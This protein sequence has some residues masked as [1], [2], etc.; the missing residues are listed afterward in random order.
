MAQASKRE[1]RDKRHRRVRKKVKGS[2]A[3]PRLYVFRSEKNIYAGLADDET[4]RTLLLV[5]SLT[6]E[7]RKR[8]K[9]GADL[10]AAREV[11]ALL[12]ARAKERRIEK[13][14]FDRGG[15]LY[16]GRVK[17]LAEGAR[18]GGLVF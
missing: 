8:L 7:L 2:A 18:K 17:A 12:A 4:G 14:V 1:R 9:T 5:S 15:F 16:H 6:K 11:G 13:V 3:R 10:T